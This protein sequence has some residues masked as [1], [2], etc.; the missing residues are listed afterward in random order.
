MYLIIFYSVPSFFSANFCYFSVVVL[1]EY[2]PSIIII[3]NHTCKF[4][5]KCPFNWVSGPVTG[6]EEHWNSL[7]R[8]RYIEI[9]QGEVYTYRNDASSVPKIRIFQFSLDF[10]SKNDASSVPGFWIFFSKIHG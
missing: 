3:P 5:I 4:M 9:E 6:Y 7:V 10:F 8:S 1:L 2:V